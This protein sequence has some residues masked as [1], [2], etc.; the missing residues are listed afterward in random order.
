MHTKIK[1]KGKDMMKSRF[2]MTLTLTLLVSCASFLTGCTKDNIVPP[3]EESE[4]VVKTARE[5]L[6]EIKGVTIIDDEMP[7]SPTPP[8]IRPGIGITSSIR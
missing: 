5:V 6:S 1:K 3:E 2:L 4:E 7:G 8:T